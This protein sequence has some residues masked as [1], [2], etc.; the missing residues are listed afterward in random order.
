HFRPQELTESLSLILLT[1]QGRVKRLPATELLNLTA[2]GLTVVKLKE[3]DSL[4]YVTLAQPTD[5][6]IIAT[7]NGRLLRFEINDQ[8]LPI[9]GRT[10]QGNQALRLRRREE[11]VGC[12]AIAPNQNLLLVSEQGYGKRIG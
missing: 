11:L 5:D 8:N 9:M 7:S 3:E 4:A 1:Q 10:A 2:R 6:L 12:V